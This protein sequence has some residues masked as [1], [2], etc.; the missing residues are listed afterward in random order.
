M[1]SLLA[2]SLVYI[3]KH[4]LNASGPPVILD[5]LEHTLDEPLDDVGGMPQ[6]VDGARDLVD[7]IRSYRAGEYAAG[8]LPTGILLEGEP[9]GGKTLLDRAI[10][11]D[12][13]CPF[14]LIETA[15]IVA[16]KWAGDAIK[17]ILR[18]FDQARRAQDRDTT[19]TVMSSEST[20]LAMVL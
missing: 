6:V 10:A 7:K 11:G 12:V 19:Q 18:V 4:K 8:N 3:V 20:H 15:Q 17:A 13:E 14:L 2:Y 16:S 9:G 1:G 5:D